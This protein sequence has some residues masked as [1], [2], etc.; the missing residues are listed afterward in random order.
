MQRE[1][2]GRDQSRE[3]PP[4]W[5]GRPPDVPVPREPPT[6][7][8]VLICCAQPTSDVVLDL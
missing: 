5:S 3:R 6:D 8:R 2:Q 4:A 7:G 1:L